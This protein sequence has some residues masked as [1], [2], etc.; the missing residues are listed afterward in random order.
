M[1]VNDFNIEIPVGEPLEII[2]GHQRKL[3][4]EYHAI[5]ER[6]VQRR[7]PSRPG[8]LGKHDGPLDIQDRFSQLHL[9]DF[10]WRITE[11]LTEASLCLG[12]HMNE[13]DEVHYLEE[14]VDALHFSIEFCIMSGIA[15][16]IDKDYAVL[17]H[18][19]RFADQYPLELRDL[20]SQDLMR[21]VIY[22]AIEKLGEACNRLKLKPW[23]S[24]GML[25]DETL[26]RQSVEEYF[27]CFINVCKASGFTPRTL[28]AMYLNKNA[29]NQ[30]RIRT[31]Y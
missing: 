15:K 29:V 16:D 25:T 5:E 2:F 19:F 1:N 12:P 10:A 21:S 18:L 11:E 28:T 27:L 4:N 14:I 13:D 24:T 8:I 6:N 30:F 23:K 31:N 22:K 26:F 3:M 17:D 9:K 7:V 20:G